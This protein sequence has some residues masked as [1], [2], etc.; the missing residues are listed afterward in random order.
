MGRALT[1][2]CL[3]VAEVYAERVLL[4]AHTPWDGE[5]I[6]ECHA[7]E[8]RCSL[9]MLERRRQK[10]KS[11]GHVAKSTHGKIV[12]YGWHD[13]EKACF[14]SFVSPLATTE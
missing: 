2:L 12:R 5:E 6:P 13:S 3:V 11:R 14:S 4:V 10:E 7:A 1:R 9:K 8:Q